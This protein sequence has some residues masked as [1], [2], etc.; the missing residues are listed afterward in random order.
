ML[1]FLESIKKLLYGTRQ[2]Y[3]IRKTLVYSTKTSALIVLLETSKNF[4]MLNYECKINEMGHQI[5]FVHEII[6]LVLS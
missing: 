1:Q 5:N 4:L 6:E 2:F 3:S